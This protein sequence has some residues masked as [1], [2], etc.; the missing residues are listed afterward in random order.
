M[1]NPCTCVQVSLQYT[2]MSVVSMCDPVHTALSLFHCLLDQNGNDLWA[3]L[4]DR[5][6]HHQR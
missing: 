1:E 5:H 6:H 3:Y 2:S 4:F